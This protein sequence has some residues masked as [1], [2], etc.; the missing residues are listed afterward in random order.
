MC[1]S[2]NH[3]LAD[4]EAEPTEQELE[5]APLAGSDMRGRLSNAADALAYMTAG[6]AFVTLVSAKSGARFT[7]RISGSADGTCYFVGLL[8]G[9]DNDTDYQYLGR[10]SRGVF[11]LGRKTPRPGDIG[12]DAPSA[13]AFD[14]SWRAIARGVLPA[15]LE[16]WHEGRCG[17]CAR[18]LTVP[19]SIARGFGPECAGKV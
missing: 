16:I 3:F 5:A 11:W 4:L 17:R 15:E 13:K 6:K 12:R 8:S 7:F 19:A 9:P 10:I 18:R 2:H 14:W 1:N